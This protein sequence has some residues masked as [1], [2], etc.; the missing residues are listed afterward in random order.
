MQAPGRRGSVL[1]SPCQRR[2][3]PSPLGQRSVLK[4]AFPS[5]QTFCHE[6][7]NPVGKLRESR[8]SHSPASSSCTLLGWLCH[9]PCVPVPRPCPSHPTL[10]C[11]RYAAD[12]GQSALSPAACS[13]R[14]VSGPFPASFWGRSSRRP[15]SRVCDCVG[16]ASGA[17]AAQTPL[18]TQF[19]PPRPVPARTRSGPKPVGAAPRKADSS[20]SCSH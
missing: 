8:G 12:P 17:D 18:G 11:S 2:R 7:S 6:R 9:G 14:L 13:P 15:R 1:R 10:G 20:A 4:P 16:S 19:P 3:L 5:P